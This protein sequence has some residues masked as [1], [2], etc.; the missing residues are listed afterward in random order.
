VPEAHRLGRG[1]RA[2]ATIG[3][4]HRA[5]LAAGAADAIP[6]RIASTTWAA[7]SDPLNLSHAMTMCP[8][9]AAIPTH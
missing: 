5:H 2:I 1:E 3:D 4:E 9:A 7:V 8:G 6:S